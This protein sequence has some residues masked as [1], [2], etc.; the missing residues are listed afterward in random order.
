MARCLFTA[1]GQLLVGGCGCVALDGQCV[2]AS[3]WWAVLGCI[4]VGEQSYVKVC[5]WV[6]VNGQLLMDSCLWAAIDSLL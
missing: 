2:V 1:V 3:C 4:V 6:A 5:W